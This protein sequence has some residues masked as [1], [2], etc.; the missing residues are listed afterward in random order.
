MP[1]RIPATLSICSSLIDQRQNVSNSFLEVA[2][3]IDEKDYLSENAGCYQR[4][5]NDCY[6]CKQ[7]ALS[8]TSLGHCKNSPGVFL[9]SISLSL[10]PPGK[11]YDAE[12]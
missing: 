1:E 3:I 7:E 8:H 6:S 9:Y 4:Q 5:G 10:H 11:V 12:K 2:K